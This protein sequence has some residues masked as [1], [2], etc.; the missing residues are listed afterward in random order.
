MVTFKHGDAGEELA[1]AAGALATLGGRLA[2]VY[3]VQVDGLT[4]NRLVVAVAKVSATPAN[5]PR[6]AGLPA[7]RPL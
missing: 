1:S 3:P 4:D 6:R 5:F 7:K 2:G